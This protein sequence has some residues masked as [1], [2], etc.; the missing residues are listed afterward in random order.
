MHRICRTCEFYDPD[1][2]DS[3]YNLSCPMVVEAHEQDKL[4]KW[5]PPELEPA[6]DH[7]RHRIR[8]SAIIRNI[9]HIEKVVKQVRFWCEHYLDPRIVP[10]PSKLTELENEL[11]DIKRGMEER[12]DRICEHFKVEMKMFHSTT[13]TVWDGNHPRWRTEMRFVVSPPGRRCDVPNISK[14]EYDGLVNRWGENFGYSAPF[15]VYV[16]EGKNRDRIYKILPANK[17]I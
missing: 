3:A 16:M 15:D 9:G 17:E 6:E 14:L 2:C 10:L 1:R 12:C 13:I 8:Y 5:K 7:P 4:N 11:N